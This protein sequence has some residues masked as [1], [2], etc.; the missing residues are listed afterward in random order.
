MLIQ[1]KRSGSNS[2]IIIEQ[3]VVTIDKL[4]EYKSI[5]PGDHKKSFEKY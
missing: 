1:E 3:I 4:S 5:T 2:K